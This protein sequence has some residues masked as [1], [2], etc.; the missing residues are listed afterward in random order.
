[1][2]QQMKNLELAIK[3]LLKFMQYEVEKHGCHIS[4]ILFNF[5]PKFT[6]HYFGD[7]PSEEVPEGEDLANFRTFSNLEDE[8]IF[9]A[10]K[11]A[12]AREY[13]QQTQHSNGV[14]REHLNSEYNI[15]AI[16]SDLGH[17]EA[18]HL[19]IEL[20][21]YKENSPKNNED[22]YLQEKSKG[23]QNSYQKYKPLKS[24]VEE[25]CKAELDRKNYSSA[26]KLCFVISKQVE[27]NY[28]TLLKNF[29]PYKN[30]LN[31]GVD[32]IKPTFYDW[33]NN[34]YKTRK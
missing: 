10:I 30:H 34:I 1:M 14:K 26:Q 18:I 22:K 20:D 32:W 6:Q 29:E 19:D 28:K 24:K 21:D 3:K 31:S 11:S 7:H 4:D 2:S 23:G 5:S 9:R 25:L 16:L 13:I 17:M 33:C 15:F 8:I 27:E 12:I